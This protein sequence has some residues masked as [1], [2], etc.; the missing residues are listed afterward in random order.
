MQYF[1]AQIAHFLMIHRQSLYAVSQSAAVA[2]L[3]A[4]WQG[5]LI[6][7]GLALCLRLAPRT[8]AAHRFALWSAGFAALLALPLIPILIPMLSHAASAPNLTE[9]AAFAVGKPLFLLDIRW[10]LALACL[11]IAASC[12]RAVDLAV[13]SLRLRRLWKSATPVE[14]AVSYAGALNLPGRRKVQI[15]TSSQLQKPGVIGFLAPR[16][17]IPEWL[18]DRLTPGEIDQIVLH[19]TEHLRRFDDWTNLIQKL[20][21]VLFPLNPALLWIERRLCLEREMACDEGVVRITQAPRAYAACLTSLAERGLSRRLEAVGALSLGAWQRRPELA[22]RVHS[23][24]RKRKSIAPPAAFG[25]LAALSLC[26][27]L[28]SV[29]LSRCPQFIAFAPSPE[30]NAAQSAAAPQTRILNAAYTPTLQEM[31]RS[32]TWSGRPSGAYLTKL[33]AIIPAV[34]SESAS[35]PKSSPRLTPS[36]NPAVPTTEQELSN[37]AP[38]ESSTETAQAQSWIVLTTW[39]QVETTPTDLETDQAEAPARESSSQ[40]DRPTIPG[41]D[42]MTVTRLIFR[43]LPANPKS[44]STSPSPTVLIRDGWIVFQL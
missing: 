33:K 34:G 13:H 10:S 2:L 16:I 6:G 27:V 44:S 21:L 24:L 39:Q 15:C 35:Y 9:T 25:L 31:G 28:G 42:R 14:I 18:F 4:L 32:S 3:T 20:S 26:L 8:R 22:R 30:N 37:S 40:P 43:V 5:P 19:E 29:E 17:L 1:A 11:W 38:F 7:F 36:R 12:Y 23:I 41:Q